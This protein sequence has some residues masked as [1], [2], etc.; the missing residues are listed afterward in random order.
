MRTIVINQ[1]DEYHIFKLD[2]WRCFWYV[3][4]S[5]RFLNFFHIHLQFYK[6]ILCRLNTNWVCKN[7][8]ASYIIFFSDFPSHIQIW[9]FII[10]I[11]F[12]HNNIYVDFAVFVYWVF[13]ISCSLLSHST[14]ELIKSIE[15]DIRIYDQLWISMLHVFLRATRGIKRKLLESM[16]VCDSE[17]LNHQ[18]IYFG[19]QIACQLWK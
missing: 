7:F 14:L 5:M 1:W 13:A 2:T 12:N 3:F 6:L 8:I 11:D 4:R 10:W 16:S 18:H 9:Y 15:I 19:M 17:I